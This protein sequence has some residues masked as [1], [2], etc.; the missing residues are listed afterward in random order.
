MS[1]LQSVPVISNTGGLPT[2]L[3]VLL[4]I[5]SVDGLLAIIEDRRR[6]HADMEANSATCHILEEET[7]V[8]KQ[9][10][11]L[12][13]GDIIQIKNREMA[14]ADVMILAV[15]EVNVEEK[16]GIC[17][18]ETKSLDGETNLKLR[19]AM[20]STIFCQTP[21]ELRSLKGLVEFEEPNTTISKFSGTFEV[22]QKGNDEEEPTSQKSPVGI[23]NMILRGCQVRN[24]E[25]IYALV[26][27]TGVDTKITQSAVESK[28]KWSKIND[29]VNQMI[30]WLFLFL[31]SVCFIA[32]SVQVAWNNE[33][34]EKAYYLLWNPSAVDQWFLGFGYYFLLMYQV[35]PVSLYVTISTVMFIQSIFMTLDLDMYDNGTRMIVRTMNLNAELGQISYLFTDKTGTLTCNVMEF[36]KCIINGMGYGTGTT[37][38]GRAAR[39]R[40]GLPDMPQDVVGTKLP[41]V[42]FSDPKMQ[43]ILSNPSHP[44]Y[45]QV[46]DFF[47]HLAICHTVIPETLSDG[48]V[49]LSASS[50]D[51]QA[52]VAGA[53]F[54][55]F[56]FDSRGAHGL[57]RI[58]MKSLDDTIL[59]YHVLHVLE[60]NSE[61]KRM[62]VIV[63]DPQHADHVLL[64]CKGADSVIEPR[65]KASDEWEKTSSLLVEYADEGLRTL[66]IAQ[67]TLSRSY[68]ENWAEKYA[69][70]GLNI[71]ELEKKK[72]GQA[73][74]IDTL[75]DEVESDLELLG[76]TAIEDKLQD[77]VPN[78]IF[79]IRT[80]GIAVWMLTGDKQETAI[81]IAF[82]CQLVHNGMR[83]VIFNLK[84]SD[85]RDLL[86]D[87][88]ALRDE[89]SNIDELTTEMEL[90]I[91][92][93]GDSLE[94]VLK[95]GE[96]QAVFVEL[97]LKATAVV[98]CRVS[99]S[100][101]A[102][103]VVMIKDACPDRRTLA[104]GDGANDVGMIQKAHVG[105]G[106]SGQEGM[107]A[108]NS[109]DYAISQFRFLGKLMLHHG[110][111]NYVRMSKLVG[112]MFYKNMVMVLAQYYYTFL[113]G[114]S[115]QKFYNEL[116]F[117]FYNIAYTS[118][119]II[120]LGVFDFD[121]PWKVGRKFPALYAPGLTSELFNSIVFLRW[122]A[123]AVFEA[124]VIFVMT[125]YGYRNGELD[126]GLSQHGIVA[127]T[128]V[129]IICNLKLGLI[130]LSW[131][132]LSMFLWIAGIVA[133]I[134]ISIIV[135]SNWVSLFYLD[136]GIFQNTLDHS[137]FWLIVPVTC[138]IAL[139]RHFTWSAV[140][141]MLY[142]TTS[143][144]VQERYVLELGSEKKINK[145]T[146]PYHTE[147][148]RKT[149]GGSNGDLMNVV[150][151]AGYAFSCDIETAHTESMIA[152]T[153]MAL[154]TSPID[155]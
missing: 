11:T 95:G 114:T 58:K 97:A 124:G 75:M 17:Y 155:N 116:G 8:D 131:T 2:N 37:E 133:W 80:A 74:L 50:P 117:Q 103:I 40:Q 86:T 152:T 148:I 35:I 142:P 89:Y 60:F 52:L 136:F 127:F 49:R 59:E 137:F 30:V 67:K 20:E 81:N 107:Q 149:S 23:H 29:T 64:L 125:V 77:G 85:E 110:R 113:T 134:P 18:V 115:G 41:Y 141:R 34:A 53:S 63:N 38:I 26:L 66:C 105:V 126:S 45:K 153:S 27:N 83:Q 151:R 128:L 42:N 61:R 104:I 43:S 56:Q 68:Y 19:Q 76:A 73:N 16:T 139:G 31:L 62:S 65:L 102:G 143:Q 122:T 94:E 5:L 71:E 79:K 112:Y 28:P 39:K 32:T 129:I 109:S 24:T 150:N 54:F 47:L 90:A 22:F 21:K 6:H 46:Y 48:T 96:L 146:S 10:G 100:Q 119:P 93:D 144:I 140:Q 25:W 91:I 44:N 88:K 51:E 12:L 147:S 106:I 101:K 57:C 7:F 72:T 15:C 145:I 1:I 130:Q 33:N 154:G 78:T 135:A 118:L 9:W 84:G 14:P 98:C 132:V 121:V 36:R 3:P 87:M 111:L 99:P 138:T 123:A 120:Y 69:Q 108:V 13:A 92:I 55:G 70:A 4:F 82:A